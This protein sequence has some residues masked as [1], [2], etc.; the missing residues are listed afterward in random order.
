MNKHRLLITLFFCTIF[1]FNVLAEIGDAEF[2]DA[3]SGFDPA[4]KLSIDY[5]DLDSLLDALV[6]NTGRSNRKKARVSHAQTGTR[7]KTSTNRATVYEGNR[8]FFEVFV[9][10]PQNKQILQ[11][12][13]SRLESIPSITP[14]ELYSSS[15]QLAYWINLYNTTLLDE[16]VKTYP[17]RELQGLLVGEESVLS[18]KL[19]RVAGVPLSLNDIQYDILMRNYDSNPLLIYGLYQ[20]IIGAPNIR[21]SAY[22]GKTVYADLND[23]AREF[24]NSNRGT[25]SQNDRVFRVSSLYQRNSVYFDDFDT[26]LSRHLQQYLE[27]QELGKLQSATRIEA[28]IDDWAV[29]DLYGSNRDFAGSFANNSGVLI[30]D[31]LFHGNSA[32][33]ATRV[34]GDKYTPELLER[35]HELNR[36]RTEEQVGTVTIEEL[37]TVPSTA[38]DID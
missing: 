28:D 32:K 38:P 30:S 21:K 24:I 18:K 26:D 27:G 36:K 10:N 35:L 8:F 37:G 20:G 29:T 19:L 15:E 3:F 13:R 1:S 14:L 9:N 25:E 23:N 33:V 16:I 4:S 12:I 2:R 31:T 11:N 22:T 6:L 34:A 17:E 7:L 5:T